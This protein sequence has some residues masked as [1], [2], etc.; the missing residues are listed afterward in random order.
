MPHD[1]TPMVDALRR[2][3]PYRNLE[4]QVEQPSG[5]RVWILVNIDALRNDAGEIVG[6]INCFQDITDRKLADERRVGL[7]NELN[8]RVKNTLATVQSIAAHT[9]GPEAKADAP[10]DFESRLMALSRAH[11]V[12]T[13]ENW[14][15]ADLHEVVSEVV[16]PLCGGSA[17]RIRFEGPEVHLSTSLALTMAI[18]IHELCTNA[19]KYGALLSNSGTIRMTWSIAHRGLDHLL[20]FRWLESGGP[21]VVFPE[22]R[23]FGTRVIERTLARDHN[24]IVK[25]EFPPT[26]VRCDF[27]IPLHEDVKASLH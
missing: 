16:M 25:F 20:Q 18:A 3:T 24:A 17:D 19:A 5:R 14:D 4:V 8:H 9:F 23:G 11:N 1:Q 21:E 12:L 26:G 6:V 15:G 10:E 2:G 27:D 22:Q 7:I 13:R